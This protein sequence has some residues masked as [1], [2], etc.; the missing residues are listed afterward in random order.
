MVRFV[1][2]FVKSQTDVTTMKTHLLLAMFLMIATQVCIATE[3][4]SVGDIQQAIETFIKSQLDGNSEYQIGKAQIDP[5]LQ[6][7][8]CG[9]ALIIS[10]QSGRLKPGINTMNVRCDADKSWSIYSIVSI[11]AFVDSWVVRTPLKRNDIIRSEHLSKEI[12][13]AA[14]LPQGYIEHAEDAIDKQVLRNIPAGTILMRGHFTEPTWVKRGEHVNI[15]SGKAGL[16]ISAPGI[17]IMDGAKDQQIA[18]K[19]ASSQKIVHAIVTAPGV[20]TVSF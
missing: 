15:Q 1:L 13:E 19:N 2:Q 17:A 4:H 6:M 3:L 16:L 9:N 11:K 8:R 10:S 18:V 5:H 12:H 7:P 14:T 20:V